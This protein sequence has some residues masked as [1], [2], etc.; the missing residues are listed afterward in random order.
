MSKWM[1]PTVC[2]LLVA[3]GIIQAAGLV[4]TAG[5][6]ISLLIIGGGVVLGAHRRG[7][8]SPRQRAVPLARPSA[9]WSPG[10]TQRA[11]RRAGG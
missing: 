6:A 4:G 7:T 2:S 11:A 5:D 9:F 3:V 8:P 10:G 1:G